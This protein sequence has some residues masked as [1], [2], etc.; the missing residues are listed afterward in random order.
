MSTVVRLDD[1]RRRKKQLLDLE[2]I[3][4]AKRF[5]IEQ[6]NSPTALAFIDNALA[7][8][9]IGDRPTMI[10]QLKQAEACLIN[11]I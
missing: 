9:M 10:Q 5:A 7:Y 4:S 1:Y 3:K 11:G 6:G 2:K 8:A